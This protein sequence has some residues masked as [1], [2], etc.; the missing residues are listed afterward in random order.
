MEARL[1]D[2]Q[3]CLMEKVREV[4][5]ARDAQTGLKSEIAS[6]RAL[7]ESAEMR[8]RRRVWLPVFLIYAAWL[9]I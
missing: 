7:I 1:L 9:T 3:N 4:T 2:V 6:L 5:V 8:C